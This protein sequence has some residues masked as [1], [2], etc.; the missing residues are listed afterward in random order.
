[1]VANANIY[2]DVYH[3]VIIKFVIYANAFKDAIY[4]IA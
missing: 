1:M 4:V 3:V 2:L